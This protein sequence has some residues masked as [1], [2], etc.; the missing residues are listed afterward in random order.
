MEKQIKLTASY[1]QLNQG[2]QRQ[3][4]EAVPIESN[5]VPDGSVRVK[6]RQYKGKF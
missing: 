2:R 6:P 4:R 5:A 3:F 1:I